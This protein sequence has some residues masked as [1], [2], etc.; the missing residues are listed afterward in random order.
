MVFVEYNFNGLPVDKHI[1]E[2]MNDVFSGP[3]DSGMYIDDS[4]GMAM[5]RLSILM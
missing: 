2:S 1:I 5:R 4:Y 3:D